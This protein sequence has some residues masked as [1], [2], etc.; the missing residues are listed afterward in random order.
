MP[1][2]DLEAFLTG[3]NKPTD[4][5]PEPAPA[6]EPEPAAA[7][8]APVAEETAPAQPEGEAE[9]QPAHEGAMVPRSALEATRRDWKEKAVRAEEQAKAKDAEL[10]RVLAEYEA[11]KKQAAQP[12]Q[13][14]QQPQAP[15][16]FAPLPNPAEDPQGYAVAVERRIM[17]E[18]L[19]FS[20]MVARKEH[21]DMDEK[22]A[23]FQRAVSQNPAI[24]AEVMNDPHP[25]ERMYREARRIEMLEQM[26]PD[27]DAFRAKIE[28]EAR[29]KWEAEYAAK[30]PPPAPPPPQINPAAGITTPSLGSARGSAPRSAPAF[31]GTPSVEQMFP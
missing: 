2:E 13:P 15:Q 19:N 20:E 6:P 9:A 11:F 27:P 30:A 7:E 21:P 25:W 24:H 12:P 3:G 4:P 16:T 29:A 8:A 5:A 26:G 22:F 17:N 1:N 31:S 28:S 14:A 23:I 10:A 18:R